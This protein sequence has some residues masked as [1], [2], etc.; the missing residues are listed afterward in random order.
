MTE[1]NTHTIATKFKV[2]EI[3]LM[4]K[5]YLVF[6]SMQIM[7]NSNYVNLATEQSVRQIS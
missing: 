4:E 2:N 7:E 5:E 6:F 1:S 3:Y